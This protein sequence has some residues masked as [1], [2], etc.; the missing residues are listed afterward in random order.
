[1]ENLDRSPQPELGGERAEAPDDASI[2][3][4][5][6]KLPAGPRAAK[7]HAEHGSAQDAVCDGDFR[8]LY[9]PAKSLIELRARFGRR[10]P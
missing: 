4:V 1:M 9:A 8:Q 7:V 5:V 6:R 2:R 10:P 3:A